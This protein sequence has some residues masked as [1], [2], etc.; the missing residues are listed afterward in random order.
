MS[1]EFKSFESPE[2]NVGGLPIVHS[3]VNNV[4]LQVAEGTQ[5]LMHY[6]VTMTPDIAQKVV[7]I[8]MESSEVK[9]QRLRPGIGVLVEGNQFTELPR[10]EKLPVIQHKYFEYNPNIMEIKVDGK[11]QKIVPQDEKVLLL[12]YSRMDRTVS[13]TLL[14]ETLRNDYG[15]PASDLGIRVAIFRLRKLIRGKKPSRDFKTPIKTVRNVGYKLVSGEELD[16]N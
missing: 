2:S 6:Y 8:L 13:N 10:E 14:S 16:A 15:E 5:G 1:P 11:V 9:M 7:P 3:E 12:L 4:D